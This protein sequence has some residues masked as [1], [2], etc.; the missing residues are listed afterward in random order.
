MHAFAVILSNTC[1]TY[2]VPLQYMIFLE[3]LTLKKTF[4]TDEL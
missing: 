1:E 4:N 3:N 2:T